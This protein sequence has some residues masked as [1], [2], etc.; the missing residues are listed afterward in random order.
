[1][2]LIEQEVSSQREIPIPEEVRRIYAL[3]RPTPM[4][5]ALRLEEAIGTKSRIYYKYEGVSPA[6]SHKSNTAIPQAYYN[7]QAGRKRIATETGAGQWGSA[8]ALGGTFF[9]LQVK[10]YMV[11]VSYDQKPYRRMYM[12]TYGAEGRRLPQPGHERGQGDPR[13][14]SGF[15]RDR[16]ASRSARRSRTPRRGR[17]PATP[18]GRC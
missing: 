8:M 2:A 13:R 9:G 3:W 17:T 5:R 4:C 11:N 16:W 10:V 14:G 15:A 18:S 12:E 1:M 6:G 7:K